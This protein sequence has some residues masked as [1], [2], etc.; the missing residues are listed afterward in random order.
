MPCRRS[1]LNTGW[2]LSFL[3]LGAGRPKRE[4][5]EAEKGRGWAQ[6]QPGDGGG[7]VQKARRGSP[8]NKIPRKRLICLRSRQGRRALAKSWFLK[9]AFIV[10]RT[11]FQTPEEGLLCAR[12]A[13]PR[14]PAAR[15]A[16]FPQAC[17]GLRLWS[18]RDPRSQRLQPRRP[19][20]SAGQW[21]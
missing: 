14:P 3:A 2:K 11:A 16:S 8:R 17:R 6:T 12:R 5:P 7:A 21:A 15:P 9:I 19:I 1:R 10:F 4:C 20:N 13:P 18:A